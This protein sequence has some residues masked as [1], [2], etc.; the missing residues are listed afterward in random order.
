[1]SDLNKARGPLNQTEY[2]TVFRDPSS[3]SFVW[4]GFTLQGL[5]EQRM[6]EG[7]RKINDLS[8][9]KTASCQRDILESADKE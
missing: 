7:L 4:H 1:V 5:Q 6:D 9:R 3:N 8:P 2:S